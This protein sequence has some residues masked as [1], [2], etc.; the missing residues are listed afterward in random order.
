MEHAG[1]LIAT[2]PVS[3]VLVTGSAWWVLRRQP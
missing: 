3:L 2:L 1:A